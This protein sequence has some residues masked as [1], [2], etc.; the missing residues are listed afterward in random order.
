MGELISAGRVQ[1]YPCGPARHPLNTIGEYLEAWLAQPSQERD[2]EIYPEAQ[3][4]SCW[5]G[6][7][8]SIGEGAEPHGCIVQDSR[9]THTGFVARDCSIRGNQI[10]TLDGQVAIADPDQLS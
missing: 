5:I 10:I 3:L 8:C 7:G 6:A 4:E 9:K 1:G 2:S